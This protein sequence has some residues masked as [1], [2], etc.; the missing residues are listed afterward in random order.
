MGVGALGLA[1]LH[2]QKR[3]DVLAEC[4]RG[5]AARQSH[6]LDHPKRVGHLDLRFGRII[7]AHRHDE[8]LASRHEQ[9]PLIGE[10]PFEAEVGFGA[11]CRVTRDH[12]HEQRAFAQLLPDA[13]IPGVTTLELAAVEPHLDPGGA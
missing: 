4:R 3:C 11:A 9:C 12:R 13:V 8:R 6:P 2:L 7:D 10:M 1:A 5:G